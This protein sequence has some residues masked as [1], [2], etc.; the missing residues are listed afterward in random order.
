MIVNDWETVVDNDQTELLDP[1]KDGVLR[2]DQVHELGDLLTGKV[3]IAQPRRG[4]T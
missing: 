2:Q 3:T 1:L 4:A